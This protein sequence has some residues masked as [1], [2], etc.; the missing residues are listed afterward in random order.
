MDKNSRNKNNA[1]IQ[2][3]H[4]LVTGIVQGVFFR[5]NTC[6]QARKEGLVGWVRNLPDGTVE[7]HAEGYPEA[8]ER[9]VNWCKQ[10]PTAASVDQLLVEQVDV[11]GYTD[12]LQC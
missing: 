11:E 5:K 8:L 7:I 9:F 3:C 4:L 10:G 12:F 2:A 1:G 6:L